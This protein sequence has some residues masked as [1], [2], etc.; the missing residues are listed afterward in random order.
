MIDMYL[1]IGWMVSFGFMVLLLL[2]LFGFADA[3]IA[4]SVYKDSTYSQQN[5]REVR[6]DAKK[7]VRRI[8]ISLAAIAPSVLLWPLGVVYVIYRLVKFGWGEDDE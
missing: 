3:Q 2:S 8:V 5:Y 6:K 1:T 7:Y 4:A